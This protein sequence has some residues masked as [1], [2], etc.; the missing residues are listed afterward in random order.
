MKYKMFVFFAFL[1]LGG[2]IYAKGGEITGVITVNSKPLPGVLVQIVGNYSKGAV[3]DH[4][5]K[6][7]MKDITEGKNKVKVSCLGFRTEEKEVEVSNNK[8]TVLHV[9]MQEDYLALDQVV[10]TGTRNE[11][12]VYKAPVIVSKISPKLL[13]ATQALSLSEG[14]A[15]SPGLRVETDCQNCGFSQVRMNG[16]DGQYSQILINSRPIYSALVGVYG[17]DMIP[18]NMIERVEVVKGGGSALYGGNAIGGTINVI[19]KDPTKD[20]FEVGINQAFVGSKSSD[21]TVTANAS[22][23][24]EDLNK[25]LSLFAFSQDRK[26]WDANDDGFSEITK[27][28]NNTFGFDAF[29]NTSSKGKLK[30]NLHNIHEFRR[31]GNKFDLEPHQ[32][33]IT[34]QLD[35]KIFST[36]VS[37]EQFTNDYKHKFALYASMQKTHRKSYY[38]GGGRMLKENETITAEDVAALYAY[39]R[40][41]DVAMASGLQYLYDISKKTNLSAGVEYRYNEVEDKMMGYGRLIDQKVHTLGSYIQLK[42]EPVNHVTLLLGGR[43]DNLNIKGDYNLGGEGFSNDKKLGVFVPRISTMVDF[44]KNIKLRVAYAQ[45]Y[46]GPQAFDEDLHIATV[47]GEA[48]FVQMANDLKTEKSDNITASLNYTKRFG[49]FQANFV[50]EG[51]YTKIE[52]PF[53]NDEVKKLASGVV[54]NEKHNGDAATVK[55]VNLEMNMAYTSALLFQAGLTLQ[56]SVYKTPQE[57]WTKP[58]DPKEQKVGQESVAS[59]KIMRS[60]DN[61]G[62]FSVT[63]KPISPLS[64]SWTGVYTGAMFTPHIIDTET[65][66]IQLVKTP[67]FFENSFKISYDWDFTEQYCLSL[68]AGV[69]NMFDSFQKDFDKG[70]SRDSTYVY[71]PRKPRTIYAGLKFSFIK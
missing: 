18:T 40:S 4:F 6:F 62:F 32:S 35:H 53:V 34:E 9:E 3:T 26:P 33:D 47:G 42:L 15:F 5:G 57:L 71:G 8:K 70:D 41:K 48:H 49:D 22:V 69:Q 17:L 37:F 64:L 63:Y 31:G 51:F 44:T 13:E 27:L 43:Y 45:G 65:E 56:K 61:Y 20:T 12:P 2:E 25:G 19:T 28:N 52:N 24:S 55:G 66:Y 29:W 11:I 59:D 10:V 50:L 30:L 68:F 7:T 54:V 23:V 46:R 14:L 58:Q 67:S 36:G 39:G 1:L 16:L 60:P 38:G 21:R